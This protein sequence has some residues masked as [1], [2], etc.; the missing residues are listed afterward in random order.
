[1][2]RCDDLAPVRTL[3]NRTRIQVADRTQI[4]AIGTKRQTK[5]LRIG[6][7]TAGD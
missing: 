2:P 3:P 7:L 5:D 1:M 6:S 4:L